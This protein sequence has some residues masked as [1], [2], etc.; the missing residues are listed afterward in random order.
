MLYDGLICASLPSRL[1]APTTTGAL[2]GLERLLF[3]GRW[4]GRRAECTLSGA[5]ALAGC[6]RAVRALDPTQIR[7]LGD[8]EELLSLTA[9]PAGWGEAP[10]PWAERLPPSWTRQPCEFT[11]QARLAPRAAVWPRSRVIAALG[12]RYTPR[13]DPEAGALVGSLRALWVPAAEEDFERDLSAALAEPAA[14][15][16]LRRSLMAWGEALSEQLAEGLEA[17]LEGA[18]VSRSGRAV[19]LWG[20]G[21]QPG[22]FDELLVGFEE[23]DRRALGPISARVGE[24]GDWPALGADGVEGRARRGRFEAAV[25]G[26]DAR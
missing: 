23:G 1:G 3:Q 4:R 17:A 9:T 12:L 14:L 24:G 15:E 16:I 13:H 21:E 11:L 18:Q 8:A 6:Y 2:D 10:G 19:A 20:Y 26:R 22:R 5:A 7:V 25:E